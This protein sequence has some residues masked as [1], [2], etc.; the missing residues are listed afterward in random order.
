MHPFSSVLLMATVLAL[1]AFG[2][3]PTS[4]ITTPAEVAAQLTKSV[5]RDVKWEAPYGAAVRSQS[6][7][8]PMTVDEFVKAIEVLNKRMQEEQPDW[9]PL[10]L[11]I[12]PN[13]LIV[14]TVA[15]PDCG[16][17]LN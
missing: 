17:P 9:A 8:R 10:V 4:R 7:T 13:A 12:H 15:Q 14:R 16:K 2:S 11:C 3:E 1:P 5:K 6:D